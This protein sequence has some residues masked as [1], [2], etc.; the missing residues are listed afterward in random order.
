MWIFIVFE[1][2]QKYFPNISLYLQGTMFH[3]MFNVFPLFGWHILVIQ[4]IQ[5]QYASFSQ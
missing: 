2:F 4:V 1:I 3:W 5:V